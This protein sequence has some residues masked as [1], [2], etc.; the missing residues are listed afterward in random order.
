MKRCPITA[1]AQPLF[2]NHMALKVL[3]FLFEGNYE[4]RW[5]FDKDSHIRQASTTYGGNGCQKEFLDTVRF[6]GLSG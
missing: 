1:F 4:R 3:S 6:S 5:R 2:R